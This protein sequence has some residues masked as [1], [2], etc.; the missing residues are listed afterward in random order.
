M[1]VSLLH[2]YFLMVTT[3]DVVAVSIYNKEMDVLGVTTVM[4]TVAHRLLCYIIHSDVYTVR[5]SLYNNH[6]LYISDKTNWAN[7][8]Q[9]DN[10]CFFQNNSA[11]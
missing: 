11:K 7:D 8:I 6:K 1:Y 3:I 10:T 2:W 4:T 9:Y 5:S